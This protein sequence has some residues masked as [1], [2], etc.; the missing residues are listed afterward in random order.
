MFREVILLEGDLQPSLISSEPFNQFPP[1]MVLDKAQSIFLS[2]L[3]CHSFFSTG[4]FRVLCLN[5]SSCLD[6]LWV[7]T[8]LVCRFSSF[9]SMSKNTSKEKESLIC[10]A[11]LLNNWIRK[12]INKGKVEKKIRPLNHNLKQIIPPFAV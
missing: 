12:K 4:N 5:I 2:G 7:Q 9:L 3:Q 11:H 10:I 6:V 8:R 1:R